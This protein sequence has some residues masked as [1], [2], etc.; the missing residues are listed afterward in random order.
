MAN[1]REREEDAQG[2]ERSS[3]RVKVFEIDG[4]DVVMQDT[5]EKVSELEATEAGP[6]ETNVQ[7]DEGNLLPPSHAL[8][9]L[10]SPACLPDGTL[11]KV[12]ETDVGI[13]EYIGH[14]I[15]TVEGIIKQRYICSISEV[16]IF[17]FTQSAGSLTSW[18]MRWTKI[19]MSFI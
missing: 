2:L 5:E 4:D 18:S 7:V 12:M 6:S 9:G 14:D 1:V 3:K 19:A 8:L 17:R 10:P 11:Q 16:T 13:S 15:P